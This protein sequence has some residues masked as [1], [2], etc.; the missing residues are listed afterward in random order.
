MS[1]HNG[2]RPDDVTA[3]EAMD[4]DVRAAYREFAGERAPEY[5]DRRVLAEARQAVASRPRGT[6]RWR[7]PLA[8]AAVITL[9]FALLL[10]FTQVGQ[11]GLNG[12]PP[13]VPELQ[14]QRLDDA[15][16][17]SLADDAPRADENAAG[18]SLPAMKSAEEKRELGERFAAPGVRSAAPAVEAVAEPEP[19]PDMEITVRSERLRRSDAPQALTESAAELA[20]GCTAAQ[21]QS[22]ETWRQ[23]I[24]GLFETG[25]REL[26]L[27]ELERF[28]EAF[29][30]AAPPAGLATD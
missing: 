15:M 3:T 20:S 17:D 18:T 27:D 28:R 21:R 5:L 8:W 4:N 14:R 7:R 13:L 26:A 6:I 23:C 29:P 12:Q 2:N 30:D 10:E 16:V 9:S 25:S 22:V 24:T 19:Q 11:E 1:S